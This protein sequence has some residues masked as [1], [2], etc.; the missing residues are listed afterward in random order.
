MNLLCVLLSTFIVKAS[1]NVDIFSKCPDFRP[2]NGFDIEEVCS[3][4]ATAFL[5]IH[6]DLFFIPQ[7]NRHY[8]GDFYGAK[9]FFF[10][11]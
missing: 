9:R 7:S 6:F 8:S 2:V 11:H 10:R 3:F 5:S 4:T 1:A